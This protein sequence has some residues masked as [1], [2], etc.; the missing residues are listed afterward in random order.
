MLR[1]GGRLL[2]DITVACLCQQEVS[3]D[4]I[5]K[6]LGNQF[7]SCGCLRNRTLRGSLVRSPEQHRIAESRG[8]D[9]HRS[10]NAFECRAIADANRIPGPSRGP[11]AFKSTSSVSAAIA[12]ATSDRHD[13][14]CRLFHRYDIG[15]FPT[16]SPV[17]WGLVIC[18]N[19][20]DP[21]SRR[22]HGMVTRPKGGRGPTATPT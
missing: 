3:E 11:G 21:P 5:G 19:G 22:I 17:L 13:G 9:E 20:A 2:E 14:Q 12:V 8:D 7:L 1:Q 6:S 18:W 15:E 4:V 16:N 10:D